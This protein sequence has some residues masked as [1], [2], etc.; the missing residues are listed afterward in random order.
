MNENIAVTIVPVVLLAIVFVVTYTALVTL[1]AALFRGQTK[2]AQDAVG[3]AP[4][5][6]LFTGFAG[7]AV[8]GAPAAW[9]YSQASVG[10]LPEFH[11]A[12]GFFIAGTILVVVPSLICLLGAPG[13]Y[14]HIGRRLAS[15]RAGEMSDLSCVILGSV[16]AITAS[17]F[18]WFGWF[19]VMP[20]LL[21]AE[22][23]AG[24]R[25]FLR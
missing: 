25:A 4:L 18:P 9:C 19:L 10:Y 12:P 11:V 8:F 20:L 16:V 22:F 2:R 3:M 14:T 1:L 6:T 7:W 21:F 5:K 13:L 24:V 23:G 15:M 17:L